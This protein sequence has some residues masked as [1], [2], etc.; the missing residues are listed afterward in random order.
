MKTKLVSIPLSFAMT[1][2]LTSFVLAR[3]ADQNKPTEKDKK[4][5]EQ[6][7]DRKD[8][9][10]R[11]IGPMGPAGPMGPMGPQGI[12]GLDGAPGAPGAP[13]RDA[14]LAEYGVATVWVQRGTGAP[15]LWGG[16]TTRLGSPVGDT[17]GGTFR[18]SC[19]AAQAPCHV[20]VAAAVLSDVPGAG[21]VGVFPRVLIQRQN[22]SGQMTYCEYGDGVDLANP[23]GIVVPQPST[24][25][26]AF[27]PLTLHIGGSADCGVPGL[28]GGKVAQITVPAGRYDVFPSF[29]FR[30]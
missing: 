27:T 11:K 7:K 17:T 13:G 6:E 5:T 9:D 21:P 20:A 4:S 18:F 16:Y 26:P 19:D 25:L 10:E 23:F 15:G 2:G 3:S 24:P 28:P 14:P 30:R 12:P 22:D 8:K 29:V 1:L